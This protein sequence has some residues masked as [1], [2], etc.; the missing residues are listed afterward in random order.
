MIKAIMEYNI[1]DM[2]AFCK[3]VKSTKDIYAFYGVLL[4]L[5]T[6]GVIGFAIYG[7]ETWAL[8]IMCSVIVI[9]AGMFLYFA[10]TV[11]KKAPERELKKIKEKYKNQP[12]YFAFDFSQFAVSPD[13]NDN[14]Q[15]IVV[16]YLDVKQVIVTKDYV[17]ILCPEKDDDFIL[18]KSAISEGTERDLDDIFNSQLR[19]RIVRK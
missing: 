4:V 3:Y 14:T 8:L 11:A 2:K 15:K 16:D 19:G 17:F 1:D 18:R 5:Y 13:L 12:L 10:M 6:A 7:I 9:I